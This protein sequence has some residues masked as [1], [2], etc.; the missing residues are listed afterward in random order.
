MDYIKVSFQSFGLYYSLPTLY[1][2]WFHVKISQIIYREQKLVVII[3]KAA[4]QKD[5]K[6]AEQKYVYIKSWSMP[7]EFLTVK[8]RNFLKVHDINP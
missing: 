4:I 1:M 3:T 8:N 2:N 7:R 6:F 5:K